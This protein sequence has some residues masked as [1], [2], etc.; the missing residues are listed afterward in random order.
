MV[1]IFNL[2][3][4]LS[5]SDFLWFQF[6]GEFLQFNMECMLKALR[7]DR[8][9]L[10]TARVYV[11]DE[12]ETDQAADSLAKSCLIIAVMF[13]QMHQIQLV[14]LYRAPPL[15]ATPLISPPPPPVCIYRAPPLKATPLISPR[16]YIQGS[17]A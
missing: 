17:P 1:L 8:N 11:K 3:P 12:T 16:M 15:K 6:P 2:M 9:K 7:M 13:S 5:S 14:C 10:D 4:D